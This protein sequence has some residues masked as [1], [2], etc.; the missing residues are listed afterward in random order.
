MSEC[1]VTKLKSSVNDREL[2]P[3]GGIVLNVL[4]EGS[5]TE[6]S[7]IRMAASSQDNPIK[8]RCNGN[9]YFRASATSEAQKDT[10]GYTGQTGYVYYYSGNL[11]SIFP[12][13][14]NYDIYIDNKYELSGLSFNGGNVGT[15]KIPMTLKEIAAYSPNLTVLDLTNVASIKDSEL[16]DLKGLT[17]LTTLILR[18]KKMVGGDLSAVSSL[19]LTRLELG[20]T[21]VYGKVESLGVGRTSGETMEIQGNGIITFNGSLLNNYWSYI[22]TFGNG[23]V[24][25]CVVKS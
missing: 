23:V 3:L 16:S 1:L 11:G 18:G 12:S 25:S 13:K 15:I 8:I 4:F 24:Q 21:N 9:G 20:G 22:V 19:K 17:K 7:Y 5:Y 6:N 10:E 14:G 2:Q